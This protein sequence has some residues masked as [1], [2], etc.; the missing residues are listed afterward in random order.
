MV[1][2]PISNSY[3][4]LKL[5]D[6]IQ[7]LGQLKPIEFHLPAEGLEITSLGSYEESP[8]AGLDPNSL[9]VLV[10]NLYK[11]KKESWKKDFSDLMANRD[12]AILQEAVLD[13]NMGGVFK[14]KFEMGIEMA[15]SF[16]NDET[17]VATGVAT[18]S[19]L[20]PISS[21]FQRSNARESVVK[22]PKVVLFN[23]YSISGSQNDLLVINI[24]AINAVSKKD[25]M[26]QVQNVASVIREH[27]GPCIW[28]GDF[29]TWSKGRT[30]ALSK[31]TR[32][33][34]FVE[35]TFEDDQRTT[36]PGARFKEK[37]DHIFVK[38][39]KIKSS[40]VYGDIEGS[41][42]KAMSV[43]LSVE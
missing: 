1:G 24:H 21:F 18:A 37:L 5:V 20:G 19:K 30:R 23:T 39:L 2:L 25:F 43:E 29:N 13:D 8:S 38:G 9:K 26:D 17:D 11:G 27:V 10:W 40:K 35:V 3:A 34:G 22:T 33:L 28:A 41:D 6:L 42:H 36:P 16:I 12:I 14:Q 32:R 7:T 4:E 31:L 15:T